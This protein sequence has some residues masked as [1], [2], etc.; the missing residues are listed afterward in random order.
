MIEM[1]ERLIQAGHAYTGGGDVYFDVLSYPEYGQL[2]GHKIDDVHQGEGV[3]AGKRTSATSLCGRAK[4]RVNRRGRR[5]GA[6]GVRAGIWNARQWLAAIS[7][8]NS[9]SIA[10]E[11]I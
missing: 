1:I 4:S 6:A 2:S 11:W 3:A 8:R 10:V 5:R 9:I 7:G